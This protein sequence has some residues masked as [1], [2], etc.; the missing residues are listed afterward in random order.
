V[1]AARS[2]PE[3]FGGRRVQW[4]RFLLVIRPLDGV[5]LPFLALRYLL[6]LNIRFQAWPY[7]NGTTIQSL[8]GQS[9]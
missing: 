6:I 7:I 2:I 4:P 9:G 3:R 1:K 5:G 8:D